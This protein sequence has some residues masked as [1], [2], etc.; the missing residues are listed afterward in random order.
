MSTYVCE[1]MATL[2][3]GVGCGSVLI[4]T[5]IYDSIHAALPLLT[6]KSVLF[7]V[8]FPDYYRMTTT[9]AEYAH[10][11]KTTVVA[12]TDS[13]KSPVVPFC[14]MYLAV[15]TQTRLFMNTIGL[16]MTLVNMIASA[17]NILQSGKQEIFTQN[18]AEFYRIY[19]K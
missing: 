1:Y 4:N 7:V 6:P 18:N 13:E 5:E 2:L 15:P 11:K 12:I 8:S 19:N 16:P 17:L 9:V 10:S 3:G 14:E